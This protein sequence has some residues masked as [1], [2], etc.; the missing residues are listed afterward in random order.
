MAHEK[1]T[2]TGDPDIINT[3]REC[4][5]YIPKLKPLDKEKKGL[6]W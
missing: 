2:D 6:I 3:D 5:E 4:S 1:N